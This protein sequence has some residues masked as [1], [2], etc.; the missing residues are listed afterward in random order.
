MYSLT[1]TEGY[2]GSLLGPELVRQG[3]EV[4]AYDGSA[5]EKI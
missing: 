4:I 2:L 1:G 5:R 3:Y